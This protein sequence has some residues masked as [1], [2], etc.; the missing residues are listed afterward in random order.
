M[1]GDDNTGAVGTNSLFVM[2]HEEIC[3]IPKDRVITYDRIFVDFRVQKADPNKVQITA[4]GNLINY[5]GE[6]TTQTADLTTAKKI[7]ETGC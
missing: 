4:G 2:S 3:N 7:F 1:Q 6:L 5:P